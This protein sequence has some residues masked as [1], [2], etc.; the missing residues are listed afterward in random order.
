MSAEGDLFRSSNAFAFKR[1]EI[2]FKELKEVAAIFQ[3]RKIEIAMSTKWRSKKA[4][5]HTFRESAAFIARRVLFKTLGI[6]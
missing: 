5:S 2:S 3:T 4:L 6:K 1:C